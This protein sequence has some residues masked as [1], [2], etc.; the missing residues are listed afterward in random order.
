[1]GGKDDGLTLENLTH[2]CTLGEIILFKFLNNL[3]YL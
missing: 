1:M 2:I 3:V